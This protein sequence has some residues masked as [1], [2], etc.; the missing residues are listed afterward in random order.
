MGF[1]YVYRLWLYR[2]AWKNAWRLKYLRYSIGLNL[3]F[4]FNFGRLHCHVFTNIFVYGVL[5]YRVQLCLVAIN[6]LVFFTSPSQRKNDCKYNFRVFRAVFSGLSNL[7]LK[8]NLLFTLFYVFK[9]WKFES[10]T[11]ERKK[12]S[13]SCLKSPATKLLSFIYFCTFVNENRSYWKNE[14]KEN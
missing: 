6:M 10:F 7:V 8:K 13:F 14:V 11:K 1:Y 2:S 5:Y 9:L 3:F 12:E 4:R